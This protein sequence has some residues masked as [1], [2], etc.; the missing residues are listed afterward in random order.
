MDMRILTL[1]HGQ[2]LQSLSDSLASI[3]TKQL[4]NLVEAVGDLQS[5]PNKNA[6]PLFAALELFDKDQKNLLEISQQIQTGRNLTVDEWLRL[7]YLATLK[8]F[9]QE[10]WD[11]F[12]SVIFQADPRLGTKV[13]TLLAFIEDVPFSEALT[14]LEKNWAQT[15]RDTKFAIAALTYVRACALISV[16]GSYGFYQQISDLLAFDRNFLVVFLAAALFKTPEVASRVDTSEW[17]DSQY[18]CMSILDNF[19]HLGDT[20][21]G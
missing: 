15:D 12:H 6:D 13:N 14:L 20:A 16:F 4:F 19:C 17:T 5:E 3:R 8:R 2:V 11:D 9:F 18:V 1:A 10:G 21:W 7:C